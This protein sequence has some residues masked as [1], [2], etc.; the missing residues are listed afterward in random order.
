MGLEERV[1]EAWQGVHD[2]AGNKESL[3][4]ACRALCQ[5]LNVP[6]TAFNARTALDLVKKKEPVETFIKVSDRYPPSF[7]TEDPEKFRVYLDTYRRI[8]KDLSTDDI[9]AFLRLV[10]SPELRQKAETWLAG[11]GGYE[12]AKPPAKKA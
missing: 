9:L 6:N 5:I 12:W 7:D 8:R 3:P 1:R 10:P 4:K 11:K 2:S